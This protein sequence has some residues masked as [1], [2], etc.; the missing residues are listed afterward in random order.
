ML[1][2]ELVIQLEFY[3]DGCQYLM[4][5]TM[6][7]SVSLSVVA[8]KPCIAFAMASVRYAGVNVIIVFLLKIKQLCRRAPFSGGKLVS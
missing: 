3:Q 6:Y 2:V 5:L 7:S 1:I 8:K 4:M